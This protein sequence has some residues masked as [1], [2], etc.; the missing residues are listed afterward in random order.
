MSDLFPTWA[1]MIKSNGEQLTGQASLHGFSSLFCNLIN[2]GCSWLL[3]MIDSIRMFVH[4]C[5]S[6]IDKIL[7][8]DAN[9]MNLFFIAFSESS[10][11]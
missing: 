9:L 5:T 10:G 11:V 4:S 6:L 8:A 7:I 1:A 2:S 3:V